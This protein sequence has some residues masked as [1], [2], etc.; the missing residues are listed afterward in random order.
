MLHLLLPLAVSLARP[1]AATSTDPAAC[2][3]LPAPGPAWPDVRAR[4]APASSELAALDAWLFPPD[5]DRGDKERRGVRTDGVLVLHRGEVVYERYAP[6]WSAERPH[7]AWPV[8]KSLMA[9]LAGLAVQQGRL[10]EEDSV[11]QHLSGLPEAACAIRVEHLLAFSSGLTWRET[12]EGESP[13]TS[14]VLAMLYGEGQADMARFVLSH[15]PAHPPGTAFQYSSGDS[16]ALSAVVGAAL[17]PV[18]GDRWP[19]TLLLDRLGVQGAAFER[20]GAGTYVGSSYLW[21]RPRDMARLGWLWLQDGCWGP[22]RLLPEGWMAWAAQ[23]NPAQRAQPLDFRPGDPIQG[24]HFWLN[25]ALPEHGAPTRPW[26]SAPEDAFA[27]L[28]HWR[29]GI[30]V[31]PSLS[32]VAV[33]TGDDRDESYTHEAFL[34]RVVALA[35]RLEQP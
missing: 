3:D 23:V 33:R 8:S 30:Y 7:L 20:D 24:R 4:A 25:Q 12:Y 15:P 19:F 31:I 34:A 6:G 13:T 14:S 28:G 22:D 29:Q 27:A 2:P 5:L 11:C 16:N 1:A 9:T 10:R 32:L 18:G 17:S 21:A 35:R 26:P